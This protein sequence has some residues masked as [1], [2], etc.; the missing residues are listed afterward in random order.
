MLGTG[1]AFEK[2]Q[3]VFW[4]EKGTGSAVLAPVLRL[5]AVVDLNPG[6]SRDV[7]VESGGERIVLYA[8]AAAC[9]VEHFR[10]ELARL[11][12]AKHAPPASRWADDAPAAKDDSDTGT[13]GP[14]VLLSISQLKTTRD[15]LAGRGLFTYLNGGPTG[16]GRRGVY[17]VPGYTATR[18]AEEV[19]E[20]K[21]KGMMRRI[22]GRE[23][24]GDMRAKLNALKERER[25]AT[26]RG[27]SRAGDGGGA[28]PPHPG[29]SGDGFAGAGK[30]PGPPF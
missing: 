20:G 2:G 6:N 11:P 28:P 5:G 16:A 4:K 3:A 22:E 10:A 12:A 21:A 14:I 15:A 24:A 9:P 23:A 27:A 29:P 30:P 18:L 25:T 26:A 1:F 8:T 13:R 19:F 7:V 17:A